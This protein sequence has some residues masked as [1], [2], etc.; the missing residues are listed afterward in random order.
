MRKRARQNPPPPLRGRVGWGVARGARQDS[1]S[2]APHAA[3]PS[4]PSPSSGEG[5]EITRRSAIALL[6]AATWPFGAR[7]QQASPPVIGFLGAASPVQHAPRAPSL[8]RGLAEGG[9]VAGRDYTID[10]RWAEGRYDE[11]PALAT[12]LVRAKVAVIVASGGVVSARAAQAA[13]STIPIVFSTSD[14]PVRAGLVASISRPGGNITGISFINAGLGGKQLELV[15]DLALKS[16]LVGVLVNPDNSSSISAARETATAAATI[17]YRTLEIVAR[18]RED[19][20]AGFTKLADAGAG[21]L[22]VTAE[23]FFQGEREL[24]SRLAAH[25]AIPTI[26]DSRDFVEVGGLMSY[27][28]S[29]ADAYRQI[30]GYVARI[31]KGDKPANLPVLQGTKFELVVN[32]KTAKALGLTLPSTITFAADEVIE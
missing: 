31:L 23:P 16:T 4:L 28:T 22:I 29:I 21:A 2:T 8:A 25:H 32:L 6:G 15:R 12:E 19:F 5:R 26:Y 27:G 1:H 24:L 18:R 3:P 20:E 11:L 30:G 13:S 17:G 7:A 9:F 14:D 10:Y